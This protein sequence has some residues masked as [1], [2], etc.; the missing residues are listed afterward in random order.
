MFDGQGLR[1]VRPTT[2]PAAPG[3]APCPRPRRTG[4]PDPTRRR[5]LDLPAADG[6]ASATARRM[7]APAID[8]DRRLARVTR[9][10]EA[11]ERDDR[12]G[13]IPA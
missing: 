13:T 7:A 9:V 1:H 5:L 6:E 11:A 4:R 3:P 10:A 12:R 2:R 8:R